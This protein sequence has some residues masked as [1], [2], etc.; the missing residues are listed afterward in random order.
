M[1]TGVVFSK[2]DLSESDG[3]RIEEMVGASVCELRSLAD[4]RRTFL[5]YTGSHQPRLAVLETATADE[6]RLLEL[7]DLAEG[8][9]I[10][11]D[12]AGSVRIV[13]DRN[14]WW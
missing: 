13:Q 5:V 2:I 10:K 8:I 7:A 9:A 4:G 1:P 11:R 6:I 14:L 12:Q 3:V